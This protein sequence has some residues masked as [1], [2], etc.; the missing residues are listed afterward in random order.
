MDRPSRAVAPGGLRRRRSDHA[1]GRPAA[2]EPN[3]HADSYADTDGYAHAHTNATAT[4]SGAD[5]DPDARRYLRRRHG[6]RQRLVRTPDS[7]MQ[8]PE[9]ELLVEPLRYVFIAW[10]GPVLGVPGRAV[11]IGGLP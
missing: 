8:R 9:L 5:T 2:T 1:P 10:R 7:T 4:N 6:A 11:L 3:G